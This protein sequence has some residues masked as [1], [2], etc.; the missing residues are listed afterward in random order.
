MSDQRIG[1]DGEK[2]MSEEN[3]DLNEQNEDVWDAP[4]LPEEIEREEPEMSEVGTLGNIFFEPGRTFL[5]LARKP[6]FII[7]GLVI[8]VAFTSFQT[9]FFE[10]IGFEKVQRARLEANSRVQRMPD[11]QREMMIQQQTSP[12]VKYITYGATPIVLI[13]LFFL[14]GL[15]YFLA[16]KALGGTSGYFQGVSIWVY[17][18]LPP[19]VLFVLVNFLVLFLKAVEDIDLVNSQGNLAQTNPSFLINSGEMPVLAAVLAT[20]DIFTIWG[21]ILA[22]I[23][24][25]KIGKLSAVSA[26]SIVLVM[27]L[28]GMALR[29]VGALFS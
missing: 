16:I 21:W 8:L 29:V 26:W 15:I 19:T 1:I 17:A 5:D 13:I 2:I 11:D 27:G 23:G 24:L 10:K 14:G 9:A 25:Q 22:A 20:F 3:S 7:A 6:R 28:L 12:V 4:G 18:S